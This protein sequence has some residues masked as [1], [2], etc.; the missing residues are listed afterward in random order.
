MIT[1]FHP[2]THQL[3]VCHS[4]RTLLIHLLLVFVLN[5]TVHQI[6]SVDLVIRYLLTDRQKEREGGYSGQI[7]QY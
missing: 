7:I 5:Q 3:E 4:H 6:T 2:S 1:H